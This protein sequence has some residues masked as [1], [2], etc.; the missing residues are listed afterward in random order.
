M[1]TC[2][3]DECNRIFVKIR[4]KKVCEKIFQVRVEKRREEKKGL[5]ECVKKNF[6][7]YFNNF[8]AETSRKKMNRKFNFVSSNMIKLIEISN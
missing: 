4:V 1:R 6:F 3:D 5:V 8:F 2:S 7:S